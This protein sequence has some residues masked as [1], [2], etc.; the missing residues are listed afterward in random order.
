VLTVLVLHRDAL[1]PAESLALGR[2]ILVDENLLE[3]NKVAHVGVAAALLRF[4]RCLLHEADFVRVLAGIAA[5]ALA[6][7]GAEDVVDAPV[8]GEVFLVG[9]LVFLCLVEIFACRVDA[10]L[11]FLDGFAFAGAATAS[12]GFGEDAVLD[13]GYTQVAQFRVEPGSDAGREIVFEF[14][15]CGIVSDLLRNML[16]S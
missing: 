7:E 4:L 14:V 10:L 5:N 6:F 12:G 16:R 2:H 11:G 8:F 9:R 15:D 1:A 13:Q 3:T